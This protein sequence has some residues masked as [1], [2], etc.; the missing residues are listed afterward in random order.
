MSKSVSQL[1]VVNLER[2]AMAD[3]LANLSMKMSDRNAQLEQ[4]RKQLA[5]LAIIDE[6]TGL[7]NR[8][9]AKQV[10]DVEIS[11]ATRAGTPLGILIS[12]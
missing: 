11:R 9:G 3:D 1:V 12:M 10:F 2:A 8:R 4:A 7:R 5:D 6:L